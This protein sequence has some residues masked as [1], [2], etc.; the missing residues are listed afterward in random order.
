[1]A[2]RIK[3]SSGIDGNLFPAEFPV[4]IKLYKLLVNQSAVPLISDHRFCL[5]IFKTF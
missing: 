1:M 2:A 3:S 4:N 5:V